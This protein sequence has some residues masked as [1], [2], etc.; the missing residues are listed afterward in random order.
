MV[1]QYA[2]PATIDAEL[3]KLMKE[4]DNL[5][6]QL[7][8]NRLQQKH[9]DDIF[10]ERGGWT[11]A[12]LVNNA[13]GHVHNTTNCTTCNKGEFAT[14][15]VWLTEY[16]GQTELEIIEA[17]GERA[18]TVCFPNAPVDLTKRPG[19]IRTDWDKERDA[20]RAEREVKQQE[21]AAKGITNPDGTPLKG[22]D[23]YTV[24]TERTAEIEAVA[25]LADIVFYRDE[26]GDH[27]WTADWAAFAKR[28][29]AA[30][31]AKRGVPETEVREAIL[32]KVAAKHKR[33]LKEMKGY[34]NHGNP[35]PLQ[36]M[37]AKDPI[38]IATEF[39]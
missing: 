12:Y 20:R 18:C 11:R 37:E 8:R 21:K 26:D 22:R 10:D 1:N 5:R 34:N 32:K 4:E 35:E 33:T 19:T 2:A 9:L 39:I 29:I 31:A 14:Q 36:K 27:P 7:E 30:L 3:L 15:F 6:R 23:G 25:G 13:D 38:A 16:S 24:K 28:A 17:A